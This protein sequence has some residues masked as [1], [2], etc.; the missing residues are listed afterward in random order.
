V[1]QIPLGPAAV[2]CGVVDHIRRYLFPAAAELGDLPYLVAG[3]AHERRLDKVVAQDL[4]AERR[5]AG[6]PGQRA[7]GRK[8]TQAHDGVVTPVVALA[9]LP[10][11]ESGGEHR[12]LQ[13]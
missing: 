6:E 10:E 11:R 4:T 5:S 9:D 12:A 2:A 1:L 7:M 8:G 3:A 13:A